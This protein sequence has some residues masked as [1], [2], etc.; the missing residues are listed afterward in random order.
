[1]RLHRE[2]STWNEVNAYLRLFIFR[3]WLKKK[4]NSTNYFEPKLSSYFT[5]LK[6]IR[7]YE[8]YFYI[9]IPIGNV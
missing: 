5:D 2:R 7:I 8:L 4:R 3:T 6:T 9:C 1:M